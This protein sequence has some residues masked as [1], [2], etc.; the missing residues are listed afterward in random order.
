MLSKSLSF[1]QPEFS[2]EEVQEIVNFPTLN[3]TFS[4]LQS[5]TQNADL[6]STVRKQLREYVQTIASNFKHAS[7]ATISTVKLRGRIGAPSVQEQE[8]ANYRKTSLRDHT[9]GITAN[10]PKQFSVIL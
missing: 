9:K 7:H 4:D 5:D 2:S 6:D 3:D 8:R 1:H 10:P